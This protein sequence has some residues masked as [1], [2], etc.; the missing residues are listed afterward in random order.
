MSKD[1]VDA[2]VAQHDFVQEAAESAEEPHRTHLAAIAKGIR[3]LKSS[4]KTEEQL[5]RP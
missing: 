4:Q 1:A 5:K 2:L 3:S